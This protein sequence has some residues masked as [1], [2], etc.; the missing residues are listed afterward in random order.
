VILFFLHVFSGNATFLLDQSG[1][2]VVKNVSM[3]FSSRVGR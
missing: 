3:R 1:F 2:T